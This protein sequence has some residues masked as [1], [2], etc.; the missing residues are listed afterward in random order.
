MGVMLRDALSKYSGLINIGPC[1]CMPIRFTEAVMQYN[2]AMET[3]LEARFE[4]FRLQASRVAN[5]L[6][7]KFMVNI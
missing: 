1:G 3:K 2:T 6:G 5:R 4:S 7:Q